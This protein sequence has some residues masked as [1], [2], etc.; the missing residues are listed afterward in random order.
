MNTLEQVLTKHDQSVLDYLDTQASVPVVDFGRQGDVIVV[1]AQ[2]TAT[3]T[4]TTALPVAG[5]PVV[6]GENGGNT[7]L[8]VGEGNVRF[9]PRTAS[10]GELALGTLTVAP[11]AIAYLIHPEHGA[12]GFLPGD[13]TIRRQR[14][15]AEELRLVTD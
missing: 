5:F 15:Q 8:L 12:I 13:Y 10:A 9:D 1:P 4:A 2:M 11:D 6:R 3:K 14:E 7:H